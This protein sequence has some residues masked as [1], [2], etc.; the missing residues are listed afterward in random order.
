MSQADRL[1]EV[2]NATEKRMQGAALIEE[3]N[4]VRG[5]LGRFAS[6]LHR[7]E[8][9]HGPLSQSVK[10]IEDDL[11]LVTTPVSQAAD[12]ATGAYVTAMID[13]MVQRRR[14][15]TASEVAQDTQDE[16]DTT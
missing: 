2:V 7:F 4:Q 11:F 1:N 8:G 14:R 3:L 6:N 5:A 13:N 10:A 15:R 16:Q 12:L 9:E